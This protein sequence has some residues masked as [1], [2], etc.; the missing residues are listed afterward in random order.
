MIVDLVEFTNQT[1]S[2]N[3]LIAEDEEKE[4]LL[5]FCEENNQ[6]EAF[7][8]LGLAYGYLQHANHLIPL[9]EIDDEIEFCFCC[10]NN[11]LFTIKLFTIQPLIFIENVFRFIT[12]LRGVVLTRGQF[13]H[14]DITICD[15][16]DVNVKGIFRLGYHV[17]ICTPT[18]LSAMRCGKAP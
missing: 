8:Y 7:Y 6:L 10:V 15:P 16:D 1:F 18:D 11:P 13:I 12:D 3:I 14:A 2:Q 9:K 5:C 17:Y 4:R